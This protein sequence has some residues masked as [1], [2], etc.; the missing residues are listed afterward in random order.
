ML[1]ARVANDLTS[2]LW[3]SIVCYYHGTFNEVYLTMPCVI[4][5][6][7]KAQVLIQ[8]ILGPKHRTQI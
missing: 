6:Y 2:Y 8:S 3:L 5:W 7:N 1:L 4:V